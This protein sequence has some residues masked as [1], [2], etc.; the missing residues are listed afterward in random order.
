M[1]QRTVRK[2][3]QAG[4]LLLQT[5]QITLLALSALSQ[6]PQRQ[7]NSSSMKNIT[8]IIV[9]VGIPSSGEILSTPGITAKIVR[10]VHTAWL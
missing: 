4:V 10:Q 9:F 3:K 1:C 8:C 6:P 2:E 7:R 5:Q